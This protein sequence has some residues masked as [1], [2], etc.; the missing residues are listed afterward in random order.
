MAT[1]QFLSNANSVGISNSTFYIAGG[2]N[3]QQSVPDLHVRLQPILDASHTRNRKTSPPD[4]MC[5]PGT[6]T[7]VIKGITDWADS[8]IEAD[9]HVYCLYGTVGSGKSSVAQAVSGESHG[10]G[11]L[12]ASHYFFRGSGDRSTMV[13]FAVT[14][15]SQMAAAIPETVPLI[16]A[17]LAK[18]PGLLKPGTLSLEF[19][20]QNLVFEPFKAAFNSSS[21]L[22]SPPGRTSPTPLPFLIVIDGLDECEDKEGMEVFLDSMLEFFEANPTVPL[23]FFITTRIEQHIQD[24]LE[25]PEVILDNLDCHGSRRDIE[26]FVEAEFQ[27]EAKRNRVIRAYIQQHGNWPTAVHRHRLIG[28]IRGSFIFASTLIK[29]ILW[30]KGDGLTPMDRLPLALE[31]NPGLDGLYMQT[32]ARVEHLPYFMDIISTITL[33][34]NS[35]SISSLAQLLQIKTFEV[36]RVLVDLQS[37]I[38]VPGADTRDVVTLY[39]TSLRDFLTT[40]SRSKRFFVSPNLYLPLSYHW[41]ITPSGGLRLESSY[42]SEFQRYWDRF[43]RFSEPTTVFTYMNQF[44][45][46]LSITTERSHWH[47]F[48]SLMN[49]RDLFSNNTAD[50]PGEHGAALASDYLTRWAEHLV[51]ALELEDSNDRQDTRTPRR[52]LLIKSPVEPMLRRAYGREMEIVGQLLVEFQNN[53][54]RAKS[55]VES[56]H[57]SSFQQAQEVVTDDIKVTG[58]RADFIFIIMDLFMSPIRLLWIFNQITSTYRQLCPLDNGNP[59]LC[60]SVKKKLR[61]SC[62]DNFMISGRIE[63]V[64]GPTQSLRSVLEETSSIHVYKETLWK[65]RL[66]GYRNIS[67]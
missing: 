51:L 64:N 17:A 10:E 60:I 5:Q 14:L 22:S 49:F 59:R 43:V 15:A 12:L 44:R 50:I 34:D 33:S 1:V 25:V 54:Q 56:K 27:R 23:R 62:P 7:E 30:N 65:H 24:R 29:Y 67:S 9:N 8:E 41:F 53:I 40:E 35:I 2:N 26:M 58:K 47:T 16:E 13:R 63:K 37:I 57:S 39:H 6:R 21:T 42:S 32:L 45:D 11:R 18:Q 28:H 4:S 31:M 36:L 38:Q 3:T 66:R 55:I 52:L 19:E 20:L 61:I 46:R 48:V